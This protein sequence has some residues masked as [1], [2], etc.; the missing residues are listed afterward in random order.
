MNSRPP[1]THRSEDALSALGIS[2]ADL[3]DAFLL[4][5]PETDSILEFHRRLLSH[6]NLAKDIKLLEI[7]CGTGRLLDGF[8][9]FAGD[10][11][12]MEPSTPYLRRARERIRSKTITLQPGGFADL[13]AQNEF[14]LITAVNGPIVYVTSSTA[15]DDALRRIFSA[16]K[17]GGVLLLDLPNFLYMLKNYDTSLLK[18]VEQQIKNYTVTRTST[19][20]FDFHDALWIHRDT[21]TFLSA[22]SP[23]QTF[24][25]EFKFAMISQTDIRSALERQGFSDVRTF[26]SWDAVMPDSI[27]GARIIIA[28]RRPA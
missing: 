14:D 23:V 22:S 12:G 3:Y 24:Q 25:N 9:S 18:P 13:H 7:G 11:V 4:K 8:S 17:S 26:P 21:Y 6:Y 5:G 20:A 19:H 28:A 15:R 2:E 16:L 10:V 27:T 1:D